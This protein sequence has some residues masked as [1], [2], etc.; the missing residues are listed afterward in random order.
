M[1]GGL[2]GGGGAL[3]TSSQLLTDTTATSGSPSVLMSWFHTEQT[4]FSQWQKHVCVASEEAAASVKVSGPELF[5]HGRS[6]IK[7]NTI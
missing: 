1:W 5:I 6:Q 4:T 3:L 7:L 2:T